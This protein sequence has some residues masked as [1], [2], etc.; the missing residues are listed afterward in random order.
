MTVGLGLLVAQAGVKQREFAGKANIQICVKDAKGGWRI[1]DELKS[2]PLNFQFSIADA[3]GSKPLSTTFAFSGRTEK[4]MQLG[5]SLKK[6]ATGSSD[7]KTGL[8]EMELPVQLSVNGKTVDAV[9]KFTTE[10]A[11]G[12]LGSIR[13]SRA[14]INE[15][16]RTAQLGMVTSSKIIDHLIAEGVINHEEQYNVSHG[17]GGGVDD[18]KAP[19]VD[20]LLIVIFGEGTLKAL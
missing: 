7:L 17:I 20:E 2:A 5:A 11:S 13:G 6:G 1:V 9:L 18:I 3:V 16:L 12:A 8:V 15:R 19:I 4:G 10:S 14:Q